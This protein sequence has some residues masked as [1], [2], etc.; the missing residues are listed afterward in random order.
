MNF[1]LLIILK[2]WFRTLLRFP[3]L[4]EESSKSSC[5]QLDALDSFG[6]GLIGKIF[7]KSI[8]LPLKT[9]MEKNLLTRTH[10]A[11]TKS[12]TKYTKY[13]FK[14][15]RELLSLLKQS[16]LSAPLLYLFLQDWYSFVSIG[17]VVSTL[18]SLFLLEQPHQWFVEQ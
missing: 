5:L 3:C 14:L 2:T 7:S 9:M 11:S 6:V 16:I 12:E 15:F 8:Y 17:W 13:L 10:R 18:A 1:N 4:Q